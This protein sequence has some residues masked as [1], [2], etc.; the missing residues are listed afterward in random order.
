LQDWLFFDPHDGCTL[1]I[2]IKVKLKK[3]SSFIT[4][5]LLCLSHPVIRI[6]YVTF[7]EV[8]NNFQIN[9]LCSKFN[10]YLTFY[11][12]CINYKWHC[13]F[14]QVCIHGLNA[15]TMAWLPASKE[16]SDL[17]ECPICREEFADPR[18]LPCVHS[19]CMD[20]IKNC[21][22]GR[23]PGDVLPCPLCRECFKIPIDGVDGLP[24]NFL[25]KKIIEMKDTA[26]DKPRPCEIC[27]QGE[28]GSSKK[29][30]AAVVFC[31]ECRQMLC[32]TC[33]DT[34]QKLSVSCAHECLRLGDGLA[35]VDMLKK[36]PNTLCTK[37]RMKKVELYC[38]DCKHAICL[39]CFIDTHKF[40]KCSDIETVAE[41]FRD[42]IK[43]DISSISASITRNRDLLD[44]KKMEEMDDVTSKFS[45]VEKEIKQQAKQLKR[46]IDSERDTLLGELSALK[47]SRAAE[48]EAAFNADDQLVKQMEQWKSHVEEL[49][50]KGTASD[51]LHETGALHDEATELLMSGGCKPNH[52]GSLN[53]FYKASDTPISGIGKVLG[54]I[55]IRVA[56]TGYYFSH[57][58]DL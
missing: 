52:L 53:V 41:E 57:C 32:A 15:D 45:K 33:Q 56:K 2:M 58:S 10:K 14:Q 24:K 20:C 50:N 31:I 26:S 34:H 3:E 7:N 46:F 40:H 12:I 22:E 21:S 19:F 25:I 5:W 43:A 36:L 8:L 55:D 4:S 27:C 11:V 9:L 6:M 35:F 13:T 30:K 28:N 44:Q 18:T 51:I 38:Y 49:I 39:M 37:H 16:L 29:K 47:R 17:I 23:R 1:N 54:K 48:V 42:L